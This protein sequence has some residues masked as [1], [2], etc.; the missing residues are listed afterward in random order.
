MKGILKLEG[1]FLLG[2][3]LSISSCGS[4]PDIPSAAD[5]ALPNVSHDSVPS[6]P[7]SG[8]GAPLVRPGDMPANSYQPQ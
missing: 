5:S 3:A 1:F 7:E 6:A 8:E 2:V 4:E